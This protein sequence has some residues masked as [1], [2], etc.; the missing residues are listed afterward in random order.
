MK[1][2]RLLLTAGLLLGVASWAGAKEAKPKSYTLQ[3]FWAHGKPS[4][5]LVQQAAKAVEERMVGMT[6]VG[7]PEKA[8]HNVEV[9]FWR[10]TFEIYVDALPFAGTRIGA[11]SNLG[12]RV[13]P[14]DRAIEAAHATRTGNAY[15]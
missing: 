2:L 8:D 13:V 3:G 15:P 11:V 1:T 12:A 7:L 5:E 10:D 4:D 6:P 14:I 9:L